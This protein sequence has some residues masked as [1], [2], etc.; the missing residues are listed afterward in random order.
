MNMNMKQ[1][2]NNIEDQ[3]SEDQSSEDYDFTESDAEDYYNYHDDFNNNENNTVLA[4]YSHPTHSNGKIPNMK[5]DNQ[6]EIVDKNYENYYNSS[7]QEEFNDK[8][9]KYLDRL[10]NYTLI[11][12]ENEKNASLQN[13]T[14][15]MKQP[16]LVF[17]KRI[18]YK[19]DEQDTQQQ[20]QQ[21][22]NQ[23][24]ISS[25]K[26]QVSN[27]QPQQSKQLH[28]LNQKLPQEKQNEQEIEKKELRKEQDIQG[29]E[30]LPPPSLEHSKHQSQ[31]SPLEYSNQQSEQSQ[32]RQ[33][34]H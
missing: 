14:R 27:Q 11:E 19:R 21:Q 2:Q 30:E 18:Q 25:Q 26:P 32:Q 15:K 10:I 1:N 12:S 6:N 33:Q 23:L 8:L 31:S 13:K 9:E 16:S 7:E 4:N 5:N 17:Q 22:P 29:V 3:S 34:L 20:Q 24:Q 28:I